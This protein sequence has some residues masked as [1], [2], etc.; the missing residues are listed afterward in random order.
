MNSVL[1]KPNIDNQPLTEPERVTVEALTDALYKLN[2]HLH[3][4]AKPIERASG[5]FAQRS[6]E[7][8]ILQA[9]AQAETLYSICKALRT[10]SWR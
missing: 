5:V 9:A 7:T 1:E 8:A 2:V 6:M 4:Y 3:G 10:R